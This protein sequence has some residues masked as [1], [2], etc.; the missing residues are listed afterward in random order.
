MKKIILF[1]IIAILP[2]CE[3]DSPTKQELS[4]YGEIHIIIENENSKKKSIS[5]SLSIYA[6]KT[7]ATIINQLEVRVLNSSNS[8]IA[9]KKLLP[10]LGY[11]EGTITVKAQ[12]NLKV[13]CIGTDNGIVERFGMDEDVDVKAGETTTVTIPSSQWYSSYIPVITSVIPNI[14]TDG[15]YNVNWYTVPTGTYYIL[16]EANIQNFTDAR[17]VYSG[18][19]TQKSFTDK[20]DGTYYYRIMVSNTFDIASGW[21]ISKSVLVS[22]FATVYTISGSVSGADGV[23]ITLSGDASDSQIVN[24][25]GFYSFT[26]DKGNSYTVTPSKQGY[27]FTPPSQTFNN[28]TANMSQ[29]FVVDK[30]PLQPDLIVLSFFGHSSGTIGTNTTV[31]LYILNQ[32]GSVADAPFDVTVYLNGNNVGD[33]TIT[34]DLA[35]GSSRTIIVPVTLLR[36]PGTYQWIAKVD[37]G[38]FVQESNENNNTRSNGNCIIYAITEK[39]PAAPTNLQAIVVSDSQIILRWSDDSNNETGFKIWRSLDGSNY[40]LLTEVYID[41]ESYADIGLIPNITYYYKITAFN[42]VG[43]SQPSNQADATPT[44]KSKIA[45]VSERDGNSEIYLMEADGS[46]QKRLTNNSAGNVSPSWSPD[47]SQIAFTSGRDGNPEIYIMNAD[48][49]NQIRLTNNIDYDALPSWSPDGSKIAFCSDRDGFGGNEIYIMNLDGT[50]QIRLT[51]SSA[52][53]YSP[54]WSPDGSKIAFDSTKN[55]DIYIMNADGTNQKNLT[56]NSYFETEPSWSPDGFKIAFRSDRDGNYGIYVMNADGSNQIRV[57]DNLTY[58][59]YHPSWSPDGSKIAFSSYRDGNMDIYIMDVDG[60]N[61]T[62]LT[63]NSAYDCEPSWSPF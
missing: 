30:K 46:N 50:N 33:E 13:L 5:D 8:L 9:S 57:T 39:V 7:S 58:N 59:H 28:V 15:S 16:Q 18:T 41:T 25:G 32:G 27:T 34:S 11:F 29:D 56:N 21:S 44:Q 17:T 62:R 4:N 38:G 60:S 36:S 52:G 12:D 61:Q 31:S 51:Y 47:G 20:I 63:D 42:A 43:Q 23:T 40:Q 24:S 45:F 1:C 19:G 22:S 49:I 2:S 10:V 53:E 37:A 35:S 48:G 26:I 55:S 3:K 54:S 14:S 6:K